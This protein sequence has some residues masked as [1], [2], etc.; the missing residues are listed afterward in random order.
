MRIITPPFIGSVTPSTHGK[1]AYDKTAVLAPELLVKGKL[2][3]GKVALD[4]SNPFYTDIAAAYVGTN[5]RE[6]RH[7]FSFLGKKE[8]HNGELSLT[9][10]TPVT[11]SPVFWPDKTSGVGNSSYSFYVRGTIINSSS[12]THTIFRWA[13]YIDSANRGGILFRHAYATKNIILYHWNDASYVSAF[14][15]TKD[16][17][18]YFEFYVE[19]DGFDYTVHDR[20]TGQSYTDALVAPRT[21]DDTEIEL[22]SD[23]VG[24]EI[25]ISYAIAFYGKSDGLRN[26]VF[27]DPC[28]FLIPIG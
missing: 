2:P 28:Q 7:D 9:Q 11:T 20:Q 1:A 19:Y 18:D 13:K 3:I 8:S 6:L 25:G 14:L 12:G 23:S 10:F 4:K 26:A 15:G 17:G 16:V 21:H 5:T 22:G 27:N 24:D